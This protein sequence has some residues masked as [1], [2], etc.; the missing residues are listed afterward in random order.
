MVPERGTRYLS[1][2]KKAHFFT[3]AAFAEVSQVKITFKFTPAAFAE[4]SQVKI[5]F[6]FTPADSRRALAGTYEH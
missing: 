5:T 4:V 3:P 2:V 1:G 6:K